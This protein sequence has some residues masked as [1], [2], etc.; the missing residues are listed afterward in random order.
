MRN[1]F[2][3]Y[4]IEAIFLLPQRHAKKLGDGGRV[5]LIDADA[6]PVRGSSQVEK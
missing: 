5:F 4:R 6:H 2:L 1:I 3:A